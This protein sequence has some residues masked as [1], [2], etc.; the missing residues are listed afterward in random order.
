MSTV[1]TLTIVKTDIR[2]FTSRSANMT[3]AG[4]DSFLNAHRESVVRV[5][6]NAGGTIVKEMGDS[7]LITFGS[8]TTALSTCIQLQREIATA[9]AMGVESARIDVRISVSAGDVLVQAGDIFGTPVNLVARLETITPVGEI[10]LTEAVYQNMNQN[11]I[12]V[13]P[14]GSFSFKGI[15]KN[16]AIY[17]TTFRHQTRAMHAA[18]LITDIEGFHQFAETAPMGDVEVVL[19]FWEEAHRVAAESNG[20]VVQHILGDAQ[21][22]TFDSVAAAISAWCDVY[23]QMQKFN[24]ER[25]SPIKVQFTCGLDLGEVRVFRSALYGRVVSGA[26]LHSSIA[27]SGALFMSETHVVNLPSALLSRLKIDAFD[28]TNSSE[29]VR[30][31]KAGSYVLL[32]LRSDS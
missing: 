4:L 13:E 5:M 17:R 27:P 18:V 32:T 29:K 20:G 3:S 21:I 24:E 8:S 22:M 10:Y 19:E 14:V 28:L 23:C 11:E 7:F 2:G 12:A 15:D 25:E 1:K 16:V 9:P 6:R 30:S 31:L 26:S